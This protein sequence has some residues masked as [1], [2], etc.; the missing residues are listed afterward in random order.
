MALAIHVLTLFPNMFSGVLGESMMKRAVEI[1]AVEIE[2]IDF[3]QYAKDRHRTVDDTPYGGGA[4]MLLKPEPLFD[5]IDD[6][7]NR[8]HPRLEPPRERVVLL[9]PSGRRFT[10]QVAEEYAQSNRIV[11]VCGHYEGFD[12]RVRQALATE[13]L[14][15]GDFVMTG[16]EIAAMA[17]ID[18]VTRL[19]PGVLGNAASLADESHVQGL[20]EYPQFTRPAVYRGLAVPEVLVSGNHQ[21]IEQWRERHALYRT[22]KYRPDLLQHEHLTPRQ[23]AWLTAFEQGDLSGIDVE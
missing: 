22:W 9:S 18:A 15:L 23:R 14:S 1:G 5:A 16:G 4:G 7:R 21:R 3:R 12:D 11:L 6:L 13:E 19:L 2:L 8:L 20:L 17:V 10:Q